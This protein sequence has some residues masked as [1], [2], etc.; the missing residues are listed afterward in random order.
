MIVNGI[1]LSGLVKVK[2]DKSLIAPLEVVSAQ[3]PGRDGDKLIKG[4][5]GTYTIPVHMR[6]TLPPREYT[7]HTRR[8]L[9]SLLFHREPVQ[10]IFD[11]EP[12]KYYMGLFSGES[13]LSNLWYTASF[14]L[15]FICDSAFAYSV[16]EREEN[17]LGEFTNRGTAPTR[18]IL[19]VTG[20]TSSELQILNERTGKFVRIVQNLVKSDT[21]IIDFTKE[22]V[23]VNGYFQPVTL[24]SDFFDIEPGT[25]SWTLSHGTGVLRFRERW[26]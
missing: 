8:K 20:A 15:E 1:N 18:G 17:N 5:L 9:A 23:T 2:A 10:V 16:I 6:L 13:E 12:D 3:I 21:V 22:K 7:F 25:N 4:H 11:D 14:D 24:E 19:T 26:I